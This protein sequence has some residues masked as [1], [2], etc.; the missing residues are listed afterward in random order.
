MTDSGR[1]TGTKKAATTA[2]GR[3]CC[4]LSRGQIVHSSTPAELV[5]SEDIKS[6]Y[7]GVA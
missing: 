6:R 2:G 5:A 1:V 7:L 3:S 4:I